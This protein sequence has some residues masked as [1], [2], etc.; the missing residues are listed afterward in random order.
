MSRILELGALKVVYKEEEEGY[1]RKNPEV[2]DIVI[3]WTN[4]K[5]AHGGSYGKSGI[6]LTGE[7]V[8]KLRAFLN[9]D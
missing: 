7:E 4:K 1:G 2:V 3:D 9:D 6:I 8:E 5:D